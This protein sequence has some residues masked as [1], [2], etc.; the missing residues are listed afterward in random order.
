MENLISRRFPS[1]KASPRRGPARADSSD[2]AAA[3]A[4]SPTGLGGVGARPGARGATGEG[5]APFSFSRAGLSHH[6]RRLCLTQGN[7]YPP[8]QSRQSGLRTQ[9]STG[10]PRALRALSA[11]QQ[12]SRGQGGPSRRL[13]LRPQRCGGAPAPRVPPEQPC[14]N[15]GA[16]RSWE[17]NAARQ[18]KPGVLVLKPP[19]FLQFAGN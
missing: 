9:S 4:P 19:A 18:G 17:P 7:I 3:A 5:A 12:N 16:S 11:Q 14:S 13:A 10:E 2:P 6:G 1:S 15:Q 8:L